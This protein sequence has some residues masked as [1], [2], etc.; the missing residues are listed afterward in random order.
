M[1]ARDDLRKLH[2]LLADMSD[3]ERRAYEKAIL[4]YPPGISAG[5][6]VV[7]A[8]YAIATVRHGADCK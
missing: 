7:W 2:A 4:R 3:G 8:E 1:S 5:E 6:R